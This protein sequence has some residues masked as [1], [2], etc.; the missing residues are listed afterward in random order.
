ML[1][2][3][4]PTQKDDNVEYDITSHKQTGQ[5][6]VNIID[7]DMKS[8]NNTGMVL[9]N[10][11]LMTQKQYDDLNELSGFVDMFHSIDKL[12]R[13]TYNVMEVRVS[14]RSKLTVDEVLEL[15]EKSA[16]EWEESMGVL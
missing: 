14:N 4:L 6:L 12:Y 15:D 2:L 3:E 9:P 5:E 13:T 10:T 1:G 8:W 7:K 16:A 11:I